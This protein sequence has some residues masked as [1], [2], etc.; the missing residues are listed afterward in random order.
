MARLSPRPEEGF[1]WSSI[2]LAQ[3][4]PFA[5]FMEKTRHFLEN[6]EFSLWSK[7]S[8]HELATDIGWLLYAT[9]QQE[10]E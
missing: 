1:V 9:R 7:A 3:S 8:D 2:I 10:E 6:Q 4:I 5:S